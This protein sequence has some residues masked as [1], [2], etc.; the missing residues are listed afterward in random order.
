MTTPADRLREINAELAALTNNMTELCAERERIYSALVCKYSGLTDKELLDIRR[1]ISTIGEIIKGENVSCAHIF[2]TDSP[3][4]SPKWSVDMTG[5]FETSSYT[6]G[7]VYRIYIRTLHASVKTVVQSMIKSSPYDDDDGP[8]TSWSS[9]E[10][11]RI[12]NPISLE[13]YYEKRV[14]Y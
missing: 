1:A 7:F 10:N 3:T 9:D 5:E 6:V 14:G 12:V 2:L 8:Q 4:E 11:I 13:E